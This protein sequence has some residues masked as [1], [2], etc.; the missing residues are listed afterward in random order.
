MYL[1]LVS[2]LFTYICVLLAVAFFTLL[3][4]KGLSYM[5]IRKGPN[6]V[7][8]AGL[9]QPLA[10]AAK[11]LT[12]EIAK[13]TS[14]NYSPYF[15]APVF[16]FILAL[17]LWQLYPSLYSSGY[18]KWGI[19]FFLC[20]SSLNVYGT[21]L[22]GW[23]SNSKYALLG[24]LRAIA[25]TIS[26]EVSM[27]LILLFPLFM[28]ATLSFIELSESQE[29]IWLSFLMLPV[30]FIWFVTCIAETNRAPFDFAE[31]ESELVSGFNIE[32]GAAGFALIF[33]A[34]YAN[35]LV[36][37]LFSAVLFFGGTSNFFFFSDITFTLKIL[38][39]AFLFIWVRASYPRFRYDL[40]MSLTWK[41]FLPVA[42]AALALIFSLS[43]FLYF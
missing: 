25:Q 40:L 43:Y 31:G 1:S 23:A 4:R 21:L 9:P 27:A 14:A 28:L 20:V 41:A 3:E 36:M 30:S 11:L 17:L 10:D 33:L 38:F 13:P 12:K 8:I 18:F 16:S 24:S 5:Q 26:Y 34:E 39:F 2:C 35:I 42:L 32:Y 19:L 7:G 15:L 29:S 6:K 22:A 37:S